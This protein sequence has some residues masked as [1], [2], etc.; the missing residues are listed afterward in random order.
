MARKRFKKP[1]AESFDINVTTLSHDG[2]GIAEREGKK[3][4]IEGA[5]PGEIITVQ[6]VREHRRFSEAKVLDVKNPSPDRVTPP[7][8]H[9]H[10]CGGCSLQHMSNTAQIEMKQQA[11]L[12]QLHHFGGLK[13]QEVLAPL[14]GPTLGYRRRGRLGVKYVFKREQI[15]VGFRE[16][17]TH[18]IADIDQCEVLDERIGHKLHELRDVVRSLDCYRT[19]PQIEL[20]M[21]DTQTALVFRHMEPLIEADKQKL[22][23]FVQQHQFELYLQSGGVESVEKAWPQHSLERLSYALPDFDL[24]MQFHPMDFTQVNATI[25]RQM[26]NKA[27]ELLAVTKEDRVLDLFCGLGNFTL[28]LARHVAHVVGVEGDERMVVRGRENAVH[29]GI[30]NAT[31]YGA[32]L[33]ADFTQAPWATE[34]FDK[35]LLDPPRSGALEIVQYL[36]KFKAKTIVYVSCNPATLA[37]DAGELVKN[38]YRLK[39]AGVMDMFPHTTHV[40][41]IALFE[42]TKN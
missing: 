4:F 22:I 10:M 23:E 3:I 42:R 2:R 13:P 24:D 18:F 25:N 7:C 19:I 41:S 31:F 34:G 36:P 26:I 12:E 39:K 8:Q 9:A 6:V 1:S 17:S 21:G 27:L 32:D 14:T 38:G 16:K 35:I 11:L 33:A 15:L 37:R 5:L 28:P 29:N 20:A 30:D 40:E